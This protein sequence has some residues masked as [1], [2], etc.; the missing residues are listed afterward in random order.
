MSKS[1]F[2]AILLAG[3]AWAQTAA[4]GERAPGVPL[5]E[6]GPV[7][8]TDFF[9]MPV[10]GAASPVTGAPYSAQSTTERVQV[11][12]DGNRIVQTT[13]A[14][15]AR[16]S[17]GRVRNENVVSGVML[18]NG[19][20][21]HLVTI[22]DPV[23]GFSYTL[24]A[25]TKTA[26][27]FPMPKGAPPLPPLPPKVTVRSGEMGGNV[28]FGPAEFHFVG[29]AQGGSEEKK[30][31]GIQM[32]EGV[33]AQGTRLT[34]TIPANAI[35]NEQPI[36]ITTETWYSP[37]LK[38]LVMSKSDDPRIGET[39]FRLT[40]IQRSEPSPSLFQI[41]ADYTVKDQPDKPFFI[42]KGTVISK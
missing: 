3:S 7:V 5:R 13:S 19:D 25:N 24:D 12:A 15:V 31:L 21:P 16:D 33:M 4:P 14:S 35:G 17:E 37:D 41:P 22:T 29:K 26:V 32:V 36:L 27:K 20:A 23:A 11:L 34:R 39:T 40:N 10:M 30:D 9:Y 6:A 8:S 42:E 1:I 38:V 28:G 18:P 2:V